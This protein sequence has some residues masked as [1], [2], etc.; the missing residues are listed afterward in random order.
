MLFV[1]GG[2]RVVFLLVADQCFD[3]LFFVFFVFFVLFVFF[4]FFVFRYVLLVL[5]RWNK[6]V[7][8][9]MVFLVF[10]QS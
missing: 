6:L 7:S 2:G 4:V 9:L 10:P 1:G 5:P 3:V 8:C